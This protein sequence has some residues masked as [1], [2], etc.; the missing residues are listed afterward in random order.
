MTALP[1]SLSAEQRQSLEALSAERVGFPRAGWDSARYPLH[2]YRFYAVDCK[3]LMRVWVAQECPS[4]AAE[5]SEPDAMLYAERTAV[6]EIR[7][8]LSVNE[9]RLLGEC[10]RDVLVT[11]QAIAK[12][13][14]ELQREVL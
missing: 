9:I 13:E 7:R 14:R 12:R 2:M 3:P 1:S 8:P 4:L 10:V 6:E 5:T 11:H